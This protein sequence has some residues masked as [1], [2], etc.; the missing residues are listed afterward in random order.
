MGMRARPRIGLRA[1]RR[2]RR[3]ATGARGDEDA[4][5]ISGMGNPRACEVPRTREA[6]ERMRSIVLAACALAAGCASST[7][8]IS[9]PAGATVVENGIAIGTTPLRVRTAGPV[10]TCHTYVLEY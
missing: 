4:S 2:G 8:I 10:M 7:R 5:P 1:A 6:R 9:H 3:R